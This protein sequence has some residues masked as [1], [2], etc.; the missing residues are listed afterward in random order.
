M[1]L[2][3]SSVLSCEKDVSISDC[4]DRNWT[5]NFHLVELLVSKYYKT[6]VLN[7]KKMLNLIIV[8]ICICGAAACLS[9][10]HFRS[11]QCQEYVY[12]SLSCCRQ[13]SSWS[14]PTNDMIRWI[15]MWCCFSVTSEIS[16]AC[17]FSSYQDTCTLLTNMCSAELLKTNEGLNDPFWS[18]ALKTKINML[19]VL[20]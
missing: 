18:A 7:G 15:K 13:Q 20:T 3:N 4:E 9:N 16:V 10:S 14:S 5:T 19:F 8:L 12:S 17:I 2:C 11:N 6:N 1:C